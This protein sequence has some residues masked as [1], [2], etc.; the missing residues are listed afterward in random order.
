MLPLP[1]PLPLPPFSSTNMSVSNVSDAQS[2]EVI[3]LFRFFDTDH[4]GLI[5]PRSASKLCEQLGF[6]LEPAHFSGD[7][8]SSPISMPDLLSWI[9]SF[10]GQCAR[11]PELALAQRF[12]LLRACDIF[13]QGSKVSK[14]ALIQFLAMEKHTVGEE[15]I[16][17]LLD[18]LG[19]DGCLSKADMATLIGANKKGKKK[20]QGR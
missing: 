3:A 20:P 12:A 14:E 10:C 4:D 15:A 2:K 7:P 11:Q 1:L 18:E 8:G 16:D 17:Q 19:T 5:S 9:D 6:H 13:A